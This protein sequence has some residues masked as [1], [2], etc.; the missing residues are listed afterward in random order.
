VDTE[1]FCNEKVNSTNFSSGWPRQI[2]VNKISKMRTLGIFIL[3]IFS[4]N[5]PNLKLSDDV[6]LL[7]LCAV[8]A[9]A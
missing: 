3:K 4:L 2:Y 9:G 8:Q 1:K 7:T 6:K 5:Q